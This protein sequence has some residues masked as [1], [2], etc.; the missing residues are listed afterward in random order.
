MFDVPP[1]SVVVTEHQVEIKICPCCG[2]RNQ[3]EFPEGVNAFTQYG[4][5]IKAFVAYFLHQHFIPF[6]RVA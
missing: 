5:R 2:K 1:I 4:E 6:E 3:G